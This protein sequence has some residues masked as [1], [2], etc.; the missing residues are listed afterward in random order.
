[1]LRAD[2]DTLTLRGEVTVEVFGPEGELKQ[3]EVDP[4]LILTVGRNMI[5][6]RLL[7]SPSLGTATH[8][9]VGTSGTAPAAGDTTITGETRVALTSKT[10]STN[11]VTYVGDWGAGVATGTLQEAGLWDA[12]SS[13]NLVGRATFSSVVKGA[14]DTLKVTWTWTLG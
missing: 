12:S 5:A 14:A 4:N 10:R 13:G 1:M 7:A 3:R 6:D 2:A 11:V 9:G 8:M